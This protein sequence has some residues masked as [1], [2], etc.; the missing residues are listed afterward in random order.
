MDPVLL[1][2]PTYYDIIPRKDARDLKTIRKK[3]DADKYNSIEAV[4]DDID[5]MVRNAVT[6]NGA[7]SDVARA[8][9]QVQV[10]AKGLIG[11]VK[12]K[13]RKEPEKGPQQPSKKAR[14]V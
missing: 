12:S 4:D 9:M 7:E 6:F 10:R 13:K 5:L 3:L 1:G 11:S 2:I 8:A 14:L